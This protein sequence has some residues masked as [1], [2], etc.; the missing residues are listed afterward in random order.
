MQEKSLSQLQR[1]FEGLKSLQTSLKEEM[2]TDLLSQ[3]S[4]DDQHEVDRLSDEIKQVNESLDT[5]KI[6][7][8]LCS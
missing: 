1:N 6:K 5:E 7:M 8:K 2:G 3:L 4:T